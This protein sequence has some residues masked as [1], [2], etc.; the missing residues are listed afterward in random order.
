[1]T[2]HPLATILCDAAHGRFP[3]VDGSVD[4]V[5]SPGPPCDALVAFTGHFVLA[6]DVDRHDIATRWP[7]GALTVPFSPA[8][9]VWLSDRIGLAPMTH[10]ALLVTIGDGSGPPPWLHPTDGATHPRVRDASRFRSI[11]SVW[12]TDD[13]GV[14]MVGH[15]VCH[16]WEVGFEVTPERRN[17]GLGRRLLAAARGL[18]PAGEPLWAQVAPGN[19]ASMRSTLAA[20]FAPV[21]AEVLFARDPKTGHDLPNLD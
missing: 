7:P 20:G 11:T 21:G 13:A 8:S 2:A 16:R 15:G 5:P 17:R 6:A 14:V 10:D 1:M 12:T 19:A 18:V 9:L 3:R 4:V